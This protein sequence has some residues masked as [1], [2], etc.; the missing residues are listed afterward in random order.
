MPLIR[1]DS[2]GENARLALWKMS[3]RVEEL[4]HPN[5]IDLTA[6]C[7]ASRLKEKLTTYALIKELTGLDSLELSYAS[8]G[9]P[10]LDGFEISIS[11]TIGWAVVVLSRNTPVAVDIEYRSDRVTRITD[12]FIR[13]DE[14]KSSVDIQLINW[15]AK[16]TMYKL[17]S[18]EQLQFHEMRLQQFTS[19]NAGKIRVEDLKY[20]KTIEVEYILNADYVLTWALFHNPSSF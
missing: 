6:F 14:D 13:A 2:I 15:S 4:P 5:H 19:S 17:F 16:E 18:E 10:L 1:I 11:H 3:E 7:S 20:P 12:R 9:K 8:S